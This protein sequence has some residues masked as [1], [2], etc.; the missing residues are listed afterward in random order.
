MASTSQPAQTASSSARPIPFPAPPPV[1]PVPITPELLNAALVPVIAAQLDA[2]G[3]THVESGAVQWLEETVIHLVQDIFDLAKERAEGTGRGRANALDVWEVIEEDGLIRGGV[4]A[5]GEIVKA[6]RGQER[7]GVR[8]DVQEPAP[9]EPTLDT[10]DGA[11]QPALLLPYA[12]AH[13]PPLP[14]THTYVFSRAP[15]EQRATSLSTLNQQV[16]ESHLAEASLRKLIKSL[17]DESDALPH[18]NGTP[19][20]S[21]AGS[22]AALMPPPFGLPPRSVAD[23]APVVNWERGRMQGR[24]WNVKG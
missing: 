11:D 24:R 16:E 20:G 5:L 18:T 2:A 13:V 23:M 22:E 14:A 21:R 10:L 12:P 3:F 1:E 6:R 9:P 4:E 17:Q 8:I 7:A 19:G 15:P